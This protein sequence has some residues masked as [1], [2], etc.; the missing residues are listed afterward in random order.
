[1]ATTTQEVRTATYEGMFLFPHSVTANLQAAV[2]HVHELLQ[3][4]EAEV[5][6][7]QKWDER[8]LA[9]DIKGNKRGVYFLVYFTAPTSKLRQLERDCNLSEQLLRYMVVKAEHVPREEMEAADKRDQL[10]DEIKMRGKSE[11]P[12][13]APT[14]PADEASEPS[15]V[16]DPGVDAELDEITD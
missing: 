2:D 12:T 14:A 11:E 3:R 13:P 7:M 1:M 15:A 10:A 6:S 8:R 5:I 9:Y 16:P 4:A